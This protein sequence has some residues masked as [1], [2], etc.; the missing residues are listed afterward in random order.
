VTGKVLG[1]NFSKDIAMVQ[2]TRRGPWPFAEMGTS[3]SLTAGDWVLAL[4]HSAGFDAARTPPVRFG[5]VISRGPGYFLTTDCTLIGGDSGG[6]LF[7]LDGKIIGINSSIGVSFKNNNHAG[8][9]GFKQDWDRIKGG[10]AWGK[11]SIDP[12]GN[13]DTPAL[14]IGFDCFRGVRGV[15]VTELIPRSPA[16]AAGVRRGDV[17]QTLNGSEISEKSQFLQI[18]AKQ[19]PADTLKLGILRD[20]TPLV[21]DVELSSRG[22]LFLE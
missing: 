18:I 4:G 5:R 11:L 2:I 21:V 1:A 14:G 12:L 17:I 7:D 19:R 13:P 3:K 8:V 16:A 6:P 15:T 22:A 9:D 20:R 10:E